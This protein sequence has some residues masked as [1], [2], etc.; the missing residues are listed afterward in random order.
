MS[1]R[2]AKIIDFWLGAGPKAWFS[3]SDAFDRAVRLEF[4]ADHFAAARGEY[5]EWVATPEG[6]LA[7]LLLLDQ[8]PRNLWRGSPHAF[9]TDPLARSIA[10]AAITRG[11]D[12]AAAPT[13]RPFFYL[14]FAHSED[15]ADQARSVALCEALEHQ[16][17]NTGSLKWARNHR[18]IIGRFGRFPHRNRSLG[19]RTTAEEQTFLDE[20]GFEG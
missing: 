2:P 20:G 1:A 10:G 4:E 14:P 17:G 13:L 16:T 5:D 18:D 9:A 7:L 3:K 15:A 6:S 8:V 19:R 12:Q 11:H